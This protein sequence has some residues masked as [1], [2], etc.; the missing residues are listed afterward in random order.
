MSA[1]YAP[2][3]RAAD[4]IEAHVAELAAALHGPAREKD[5][6]LAELREGLVDA[7]AD[8]SADTAPDPGPRTGTTPDAAHE[9]IRQ[10]GAV[11]DLAPGFQREL[12]VAQARHTAR[13]VMLVVPFLLPCWYVLATAAGPAAE[14]LPHPAQVLL[15]HLGGTAAATALAAAVF[16]AATGPLARRLP[17]PDR[18][19]L[20]VAWTGTT[21]AV[22]LALS[23][24]TLT[25]ASLLTANWPLSV[26]A[27]A[28]TIACH[29]KIAASARA[30]RRCARLPVAAPA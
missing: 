12:T 2:T 3:E 29:S 4:P 26:L 7:A 27:G 28:V 21:A 17:T 25:L 14:R 18:L 5:R 13:G 10:F 15:A 9:A 23:A 19:P 20:L 6:M 30:C 16:L 22:A 1:P 11:A 8:L 24:L